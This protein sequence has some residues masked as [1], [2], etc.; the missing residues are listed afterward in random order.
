NAEARIEDS[1]AAAIRLALAEGEGG[2]LAFLPG[3]AEIER[4]AERVTVPD[5][6]VLHRLHG[7]LLPAEQRAAIAPDPQGRRKIVLATS[8]AETS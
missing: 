5:G 8:I 6:A 7:T 4:T 3:V 2:I 1:V